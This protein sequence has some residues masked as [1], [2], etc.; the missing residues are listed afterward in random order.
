MYVCHCKVISDRTVNAA[1]ASGAQTVA[2]ITSR[3]TAGGGCGGCH[4]LLQAM[5]D[6]ADGCA[7]V[8]APAA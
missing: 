6:A 4:R 2:D 7:M 8:G 3:C 1:I 5:I